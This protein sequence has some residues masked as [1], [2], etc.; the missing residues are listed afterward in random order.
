M[1]SLRELTHEEVAEGEGLWLPEQYRRAKN[2]LV[3]MTQATFPKYAV[4][5]HHMVMWDYIRRWLIGEIPFLIIE[6][7]PRHGKTELVSRRLPAFIFGRQP[8]AQIIAASY[9]SDLAS[10]NNRDVQRVIDSPSYQRIFPDIRLSGSQNRAMSTG[11]YLRNSSEFEIV[12]HKGYYRSAGVGGGITGMGATHFLI[13]D[14]FKNR[15]EADSKT[16]RDAVWDWWTSTAMTRLEKD[17]RVLLINT[18]WHEDDLA[19]RLLAKSKSDPEA[20]QFVRL[21]M[22]AIKEGTPG[23][24]PEDK[25]KLGEALWPGKYDQ[26]R[27]GS[28]RGTTTLRDWNALYQ[29][30]PS[31]Q[32]GEIIQEKWIQ[33]YTELPPTFHKLI[34]SWD[35]TF[36]EGTDNDFVV[37]QVWGVYG[38]K[39]YLLAQVRERMGFV[40]SLAAVRLMTKNWP[41]ALLKLIEDKANGPAII[42]ALQ[43]A[44]PERGIPAINGVTPFKPKGQKGERLEAVSPLFMAGDVFYPHPSIAPWISVN[45]DEIVKFKLSGPGTANDDT[46]DATTQALL[47]LTG[48][49]ENVLSKTSRL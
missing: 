33:Y 8:D 25:R 29:Q 10:K 18:R 49:G 47:H 14:P 22:P 36:K 44:D 39:Y 38:R 4:N 37:G 1:A 3:I 19:G 46:V 9:G 34:Q 11:K 5:W 13:D 35:M 31:V 17:S 42:D 6:I 24:V 28:I 15:K 32:G 43:T 16:V 23:E 27:L 30:N 12:G 26:K 21:R 2:N 48:A 45:I 40:K 7:P 20:F 41:K